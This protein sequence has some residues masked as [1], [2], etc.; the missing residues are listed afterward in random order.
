M[1][2]AYVSEALRKSVAEA[3]RYRCGYC[4]TLEEIV[5][6]PLHVEHIHPRA[7]GGPSTEENLWLACSVSNNYKGSQIE[8]EDPVTKSLT[9]LFNPRT[10]NWAEH[11]AWSDDG[12]YINGLTPVG[13][14]TI[15]ALQLNAPVRVHAR[16]RWTTAGWHPPKD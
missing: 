5:G 16:R 4:Q 15:I 12:T 14:A 10:Q 6:Y 7:L 13:R 3:A 8:A 11:F 1:S 9:S 2:R